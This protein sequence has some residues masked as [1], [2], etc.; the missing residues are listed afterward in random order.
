MT[1]ATALEA[2]ADES[3]LAECIDDCY[4]AMGGWQPA[5]ARF[6]ELVRAQALEDAAKVCD[7]SWP[8]MH[9][10]WG[11]GQARAACEDCAA[12]IRAL[13]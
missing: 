5:L 9:K 3:G 8:E 10:Y 11:D 7:A 2:L 12:A 1:D 4:L 13:P 6:A